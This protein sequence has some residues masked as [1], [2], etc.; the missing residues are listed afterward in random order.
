MDGQTQGHE[1]MLNWSLSLQP[2]DFTVIHCNGPNNG[3]VDGLS[4]MPW[5]NSNSAASLLPEKEAQ[6]MTDII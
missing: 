3:N 2:F 4:R 1:F 6:D 5:C